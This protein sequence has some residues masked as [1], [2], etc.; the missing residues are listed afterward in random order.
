MKYLYGDSSP[1]PLEFNF[2]Q[3]LRETVDF[4]VQVLQAEQRMQGESGRAAERRR[5]GD[6]ELAKVEGLASVVQKALEESA[7]PSSDSPSGRCAAA[8]TK[9]AA[10]LCKAE[11]ERARA[12]FAEVLGKIEAQIAKER[13]A[14]A[15]SL[16]KFVLKQDLINSRIGI[17]L[18]LREGTRFEAR[19]TMS[20]PYGAEAVLDL[21]VPPTHAFAR[22]LR[23]DRFAENL[24]ME[25]PEG[26]WLSKETK[27]RPHRLDKYFITEVSV[28]PDQMT[29]KLRQNADGTGRG[30]DAKFRRQPPQVLLSRVDDPPKSNEQPPLEIKASELPK[31]M[32]VWDALASSIGELGKS[33]RALVQVT[34]DG[35]ALKDHERP[36]VLLERIIARMAPIVQEVVRHSPSPNELVLK[37]LLGDDRREEIF[38]SKDELRK[39]VEGLPSSMLRVLEPLGLFFAAAGRAEP[40]PSVAEQRPPVPA[41]GEHRPA[42]GAA[43]APLPPPDLQSLPD[44]PIAPDSETPK[45]KAEIYYKRAISRMR[46]GEIAA[47]LSDYDRALELRPNYAEAYANRAAAR[48]TN[49]DMGGAISDLES[50]LNA[51]P[52]GWKYREKVEH[53]LEVARQHAKSKV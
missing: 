8:I 15:K 43:P 37:R 5:A 23:L 46:L 27:L 12:A 45:D 34:V 42:N 17:S 6:V 39:K 10:D 48:Q 30:F 32:G 19:M 35:K 22:G 29:L 25:T 36:S 14:C 41:S 20:T 31:F 50:A 33:R 4:A 26:G 44:A 11:A 3:C 53:L 47:A 9:A 13:E 1:S 16:E 51:A 28:A 49:G 2:I 24:E 40:A 18:L 21:D 52:P 7:R 38:L